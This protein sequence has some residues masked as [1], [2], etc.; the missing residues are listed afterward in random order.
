[1]RVVILLKRFEMVDVMV[2][3]VAVLEDEAVLGALAVLLVLIGGSA[4]T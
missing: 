4:V 2:F 1:M 3:I